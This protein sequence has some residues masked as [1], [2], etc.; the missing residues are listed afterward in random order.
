MSGLNQQFAKLP[1]G[2]TVPGVRIP[3]SPL[4]E[5][6]F[7]MINFGAVSF[8]FV[9]DLALIPIIA[10]QFVFMTHRLSAFLQGSVL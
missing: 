10:Q 4:K 5:T 1:Y 6:V 2:I 9:N 8:V 3:L 7:K